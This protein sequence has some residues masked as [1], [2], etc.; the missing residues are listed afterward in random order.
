[1]PFVAQTNGHKTQPKPIGPKSKVL[2]GCAHD[3]MVYQASLF[4]VWVAGLFCVFLLLLLNCQ[5]QASSYI[6]VIGVVFASSL[7]LHS[8]YSLSHI[9]FIINNLG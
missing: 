8:A 6:L 2:K 7:E 4:F 9:Q 1:M 5:L 3:K